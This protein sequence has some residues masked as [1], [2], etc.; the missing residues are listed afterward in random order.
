MK[1]SHI[2]CPKASSNGTSRLLLL[3]AESKLRIEFR[4][5]PPCCHAHSGIGSPS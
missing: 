3:K 4:E 2:S 1:A 5:I